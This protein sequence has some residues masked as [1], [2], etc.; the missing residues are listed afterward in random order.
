MYSI[1]EENYLKAIYKLSEAGGGAVSTNAIAEAT[2]TRAASVTDMIRKLSEKKLLKYEKYRG[3]TLTQKGKSVA[4]E[5]VR[6]HRL[7][8]VF[9]CDKLQFGW[10]EVHDIA[11]Q[12]EHIQST[13]L[14]DK[15]DEFL[16][17]PTHDPHGD[18][19]PTKDGEFKKSEFVLLNTIPLYKEAVMSGVADHSTLF[20]QYLDKIGLTLGK[21]CEVTE[22]NA[23]DGSMKLLLNKKQ[24]T[25]ISKEVARNVFVKLV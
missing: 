18:P 9:L 13:L 10:D 1:T 11:E 23:Y 4:L 12:L 17:F 25:D 7:W 21:I 8:E 19:I 22:V 16:G 2:Q 5:T 24:K 14:V 6:K 15:L 20:L 3:V